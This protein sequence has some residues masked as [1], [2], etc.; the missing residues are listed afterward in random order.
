MG[1]IASSPDR[2]NLTHTHPTTN[3][4]QLPDTCLAYSW[5]IISWST[6][7][8]RPIIPSEQASQLLRVCL[9]E[10]GLEVLC[11]RQLQVELVVVVLRERRQAQVLM[12][13]KS[14]EG[15]SGA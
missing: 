15:Q 14:R 10:H 12:P 8:W 6:D 4:Q 1:R 13:A 2:P 11:G 3:H 5:L 9:G 7:Y